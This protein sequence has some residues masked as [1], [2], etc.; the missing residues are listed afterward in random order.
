MRAVFAVLLV[1]LVASSSAVSFA[2][3]GKGLLD[4]LK[5]A[6]LNAVQGLVDQGKTLVSAAVQSLPDMLSKVLFGKRELTFVDKLKGFGQKLSELV[7][8]AKGHAS[9]VFGASVDK[10]KELL[11]KFHTKLGTDADVKAAGDEVDKVVDEHHKMQRR[12]ISSLLEGGKNLL[13]GLVD[14]VKNVAGNVFASAKAKMSEIA[15]GIV[16]KGAELLAKTGLLGKRAVLSL[17]DHLT[18]IGKAL[19]PVLDPFKDIVSNL[20]ATL[21]GHFSNLV[22]T[23]KGHVSTLKDKLAGHVSDLAGHG[24]KLLEHGKNAL[25]ALGEVANDVLKQTLT[26]AKPH[27]DGIA[28][29]LTDGA[30]VVGNHINGN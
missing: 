25:T 6:G 19:S 21:K 30:Q 2:D 14:S 17:T 7:E 24:S 29:V 16:Q 4:N 23:V 20:G 9:K 3:L 27:I 13:S 10:L 12:I 15:S 28:K 8:K 5:Q 1:A 18:N 11:A 22:D 26:N